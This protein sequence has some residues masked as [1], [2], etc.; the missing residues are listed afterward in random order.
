MAISLRRQVNG[1]FGA[2]FVGLDATPTGSDASADVVAD[3]TGATTT[4]FPDQSSAAPITPVHS[5][6]LGSTFKIGVRG[7]WEVKAEVPVATAASV[8]A[9]LNLDGVAGDLNT[10]PAAASQRNRA[11]SRWVGTAAGEADTK[12]LTANILVT[13][14]MA[15]DAAQGIVR[16]LLSNAAGAGATAASLAILTNARLTFTWLADVP[17]GD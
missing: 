14:T 11:F 15:D 5:Q 6:T 8:L 12:T 9:A 2:L 10:D 17:P 3:F 16:L 7:I 1:R 4:N 13:Q